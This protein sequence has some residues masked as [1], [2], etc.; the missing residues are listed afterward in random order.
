MQT[1]SWHRDLV[2]E[3]RA[4]H[5]HTAFAMWRIVLS[6]VFNI[7]HGWWGNPSFENPNQICQFF[8]TCD[9]KNNFF[10]SFKNEKK[11]DFLEK[12]TSMNLDITLKIIPALRRSMTRLCI[13]NSRWILDVVQLIPTIHYIKVRF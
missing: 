1:P 9:G 4:Q 10:Q 2:S 13:L 11:S 3:R 5:G 12:K 6:I 8:L 7:Q